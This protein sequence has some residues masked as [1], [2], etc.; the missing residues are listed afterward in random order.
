MANT[1]EGFKKE[2]VTALCTA[3]STGVLCLQHFWGIFAPEGT[4]QVAYIPLIVTFTVLI[5]SEAEGNYEKKKGIISLSLVG[6][7]ILAIVGFSISNIVEYGI[8][9]VSVLFLDIK[10]NEGAITING[11]TLTV[12]MYIFITI[13]T[14]GLT[15][16]GIKKCTEV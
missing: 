13:I 1:K 16:L 4:V 2:K 6:I 15:I 12:V 8:T 11:K 7:A 10:I 9:Q 5:A 3:I 14:L